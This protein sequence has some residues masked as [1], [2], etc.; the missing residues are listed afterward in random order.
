VCG[1]KAFLLFH[2][3]LNC[4]ESVK[5]NNIE[6]ARS[7]GAR[8]PPPVCEWELKPRCLRDWVLDISKVARRAVCEREVFTDAPLQ[9][10]AQTHL[11]KKFVPPLPVYQKRRSS[12]PYFCQQTSR[13]RHLS[14]IWMDSCAST[15]AFPVTDREKGHL[16]Y[17]TK[18]NWS[19]GYI[20]PPNF[21]IIDYQGTFCR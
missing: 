10:G 16:L 8:A 7:S 4:H 3:I 13:N 18:Q 14:T 21:H 5:N 6:R 19:Q 1:H 15:L 11:P 2:D 9:K 12:G 20:C 17:A